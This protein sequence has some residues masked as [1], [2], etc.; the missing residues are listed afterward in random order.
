MRS[1]MF[2]RCEGLTVQKSA[3]YALVLLAVL[4]LE[5]MYQYLEE[6]HPRQSVAND[7]RLN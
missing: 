4:A 7:T 5:L 2:F 1:P 3:L 6:S